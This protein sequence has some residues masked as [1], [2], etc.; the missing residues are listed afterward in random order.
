MA[1]ELQ[2]PVAA[3]ELYGAVARAGEMVLPL[4]AVDLPVDGGVLA[5]VAAHD[6]LGG[7]GGGFVDADHELAG[8][9]ECGVE[10]AGD[11]AP[12][13]LEDEEGGDGRVQFIYL[14]SSEC[15]KCHAQSSP[16]PGISSH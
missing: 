3:A 13:V 9:R 16:I 8:D 10:R 5:G 6:L 14:M 7:V 12:L 15:T 11:G 1:V 4:E 2:H